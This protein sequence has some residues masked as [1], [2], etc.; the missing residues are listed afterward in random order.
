MRPS[1][2]GQESIRKI[3]D[4]VN[5]AKVKTPKGAFQ[6]LTRLAHEKERLSKEMRECERKL[7]RVKSRLEEISKTE[8][9]VWGFAG[10]DP[11]VSPTRQGIPSPSI[12]GRGS[13]AEAPEV[14]QVTVRY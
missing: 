6:Q 12:R 2:K 10:L 13:S 4:R 3:T 14:K 7:E 11:K 5:M 8:D 1:I 9:W